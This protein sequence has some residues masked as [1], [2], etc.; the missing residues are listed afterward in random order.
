MDRAGRCKQR[1]LHARHV[2][3]GC[4]HL[5]GPWHGALRERTSYG[6]RVCGAGTERRWQWVH[7]RLFERWSGELVQRAYG[8]AHC[9]WYLDR[10]VRCGAFRNVPAGH[11]TRW[12]LH[13]PCGRYRPV[14]R[15]HCSGASGAH[16]G[17]ER[18]YG[19]H[20]H[21]MQHQCPL[22][23]GERTWRVTQQ[24]RYVDRSGWRE[25]WHLHTGYKRT[26]AIS[27]RGGGHGALSQ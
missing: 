18:G 13:L 12:Q 21:R 3:A 26:G 7:Y 1:H 17:C 20:H 4:L 25:Q 15:C 19:W 24:R 5:H 8:H 11:T 10:T 22:P 23:A 9:G 27:V 2:T 6:H 16:T 14:Q